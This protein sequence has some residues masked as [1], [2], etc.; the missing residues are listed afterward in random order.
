[1]SLKMIVMLQNM[2]QTLC[3]GLLQRLE[4][5]GDVEHPP[6][7]VSAECS[8]SN[9]GDV[10]HWL[11]FSPHLCI[12]REEKNRPVVYNSLISLEHALKCKRV[13]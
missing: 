12:L 13:Q 4:K 5:S 7:G 9:R 1:M 3:V 6:L 11:H 2:S 10:K 8:Q